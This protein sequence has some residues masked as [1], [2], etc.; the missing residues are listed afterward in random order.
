MST[1]LKYFILACLLGI[2]FL[3]NAVSAQTVTYQFQVRDDENNPVKK[4]RLFLNNELVKTDNA[5][6]L[7]IAFKADVHR[8]T[9]SLDTS[10]LK[11]KITTPM[12]GVLNLPSNPDDISTIV[13]TDPNKV[14]NKDLAL[15]I[16]QL[17]DEIRK[18]S[19]GKSEEKAALIKQ[20]KELKAVGIKTNLTKDQIKTTGKI[21]KGKKKAF[22]SMSEILN[23]YVVKVKNVYIAFKFLADLKPELQ[24][25]AYDN[26]IVA[27]KDYNEAYDKWEA[28]QVNITQDL[29]TYWKSKELSLKYDNLK[30][31]AFIDIHRTIITPLIEVS[32]FIHQ[33]NSEKKS[34]QNKKV[35][36]SI[37]YNL[38]AHLIKL[39]SR[40]QIITEKTNSFIIA[41]N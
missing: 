3:F 4:A 2:I 33:Y 10:N 21:V 20:I 7:Q 26:V 41:M 36:E 37:V 30:E 35:M 19:Q 25:Q 11:L 14:V 28:Q 13:L 32:N 34:K 24:M 38:T 39:N 17:Q 8:V 1:G 9:V 5:G 31:Y 27:I 40:N 12:D 29:Q 22:N 23:N 6:G 15:Q 18:L 16:I